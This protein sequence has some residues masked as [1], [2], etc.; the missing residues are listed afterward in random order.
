MVDLRTNKNYKQIFWNMIYYFNEYMLP[1]EF[2]LPYED[3]Q[4]EMDFQ[5]YKKK[6]KKHVDISQSDF[7][8][9]VRL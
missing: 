3:P 2:I 5:N 1:F 6:Q 7:P 8:T 4:F 9:N